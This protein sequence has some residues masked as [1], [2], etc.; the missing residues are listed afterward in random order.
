MFNVSFQDVNTFQDFKVNNLNIAP[1]QQ[2]INTPSPREFLSF[3]SLGL[4]F[5]DS[6]GSGSGSLGHDIIYVKL[7]NIYIYFERAAKRKDRT[8][9]IHER[10]SAR[11]RTTLITTY[12]Y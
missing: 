2:M 12:Y 1:E 11:S 4:G 6:A 9:F 3:R 7:L 10:R 8:V 5:L